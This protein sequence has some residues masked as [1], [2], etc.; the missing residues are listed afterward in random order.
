MTQFFINIMIGVF[1]N[2][3][4]QALLRQM[5]MDAEK[6]MQ[7]AVLER[8]DKFEKDALAKLEALPGEILGDA[9]KDVGILLHEIT[10]TKTDIAGAVRG[11]VQPLLPTIDSLQTMFLNVIRDLPGGGLLGG[12]LGR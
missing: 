8:L 5:F 11:E 6:Q 9:S 12:I 4:V 7:D 10:G 3:Q 1:E 2:P